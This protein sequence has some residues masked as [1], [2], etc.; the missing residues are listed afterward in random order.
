[1]IANT[2]TIL[3]GPDPS[4]EQLQLAIQPRDFT[5]L[6]A[7]VAL[8]LALVGPAEELAFRGFIQRGF[9]NSFGKTP[10]LL[11]ASVLFAL[12]HGLNSLYSIAPIL[13]VALALGYMWQRGGGNTTATLLMHGVYNSVQIILLYFITI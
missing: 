6:I 11:S 2:E 1:M 5:Q 3:F 8:N 12:L 13:A 10:G 7:L 9:E 4:A